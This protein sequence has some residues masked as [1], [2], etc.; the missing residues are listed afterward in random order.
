MNTP[1]S[2]V[3]ASGSPRREQLLRQLAVTFR[4]APADIDESVVSG[5]TPRDY[6]QRMALEKAL[7]AGGQLLVMSHLGRPKEGVPIEEQP[8][9]SLAPVA[10]YLEQALGRAVPLVKDWL[11][12]DLPAGDV[13]V[14]SVHRR[15]PDDQ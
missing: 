15:R 13:G 3:L 5:E 9:M 12:G 6:V 7:A 8:E 1:H 4:V 11:G 10:A 2:L 14:S